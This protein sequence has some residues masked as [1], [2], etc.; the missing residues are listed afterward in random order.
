MRAAARHGL[1]ER[2]SNAVTRARDENDAIT[3][4]VGSGGEGG[5]N[6]HGNEGTALKFWLEGSLQSTVCRKELWLPTADLS[7]TPCPNRRLPRRPYFLER[8]E[9]DAALGDVVGFTLQATEQTGVQTS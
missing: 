6:G 7:L 5:G 8:T 9:L 4:E 3:E 2:A 1:R